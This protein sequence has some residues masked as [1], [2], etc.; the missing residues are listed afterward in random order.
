MNGS[1]EWTVHVTAVTDNDGNAV[2]R[3]E[4]HADTMAAAD[5]ML[6]ALGFIPVVNDEEE[7]R[8]REENVRTLS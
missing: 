4:I 7:V 1:G 5:A 3:T 8:D 6:T 2:T